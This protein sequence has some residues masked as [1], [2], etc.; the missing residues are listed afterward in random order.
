[1]G[2]RNL[3]TSV[4]EALAPTLAAIAAWQAGGERANAPIP[5]ATTVDV[6]PML[7]RLQVLL[8]RYDGEAVDV[9]E[10]L[11]QATMGDIREPE[12]RRLRKLVD[13]FEFDDALAVVA[14]L[15]GAAGAP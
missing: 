1:M 10:E 5:T 11:E 15:R 14:A 8:E 2:M 6:A 9:I 3:V 4:E 13:D 7:D 12:V